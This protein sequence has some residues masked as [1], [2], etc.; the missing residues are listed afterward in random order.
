[1][2]E[3]LEQ[4]VDGAGGPPGG[5]IANASEESACTIIGLAMGALPIENRHDILNTVARFAA[6]NQ[7]IAMV[8]LFGPG[9]ERGICACWPILVPLGRYL[10]TV[11]REHDVRKG[12]EEA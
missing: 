8:G 9:S 6:D 10:E 1:M 2:I 4:V 3:P 11:I 5:E 7:C 12:V